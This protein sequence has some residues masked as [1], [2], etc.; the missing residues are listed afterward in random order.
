MTQPLLASSSTLLGSVQNNTSLHNNPPP[1]TV[2]EPENSDQQLLEAFQA[3]VAHAASAMTP[4]AAV[5]ITYSPDS[6]QVDNPATTIIPSIPGVLPSI[7]SAAIHDPTPTTP[8]IP[9]P[10]GPSTLP[11]LSP[12]SPTPITNPPSS[13]TYHYSSLKLPRVRNNK[14]PAG[15]KG[16]HQNLTAKEMLDFAPISTS[17]LT[18][19]SFW[20]SHSASAPSSRSPRPALPSGTNGVVGLA[21]AFQSSS[22]LTNG[23]AGIDLSQFVNV[24]CA[25]TATTMPPSVEHPRSI[26]P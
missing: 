24:S 23:F 14:H 10:T 21:P 3:V 1:T 12:Q 19:D 20:S 9:A 8:T 6:M 5:N 13:S 18:Y 16:A 7:P 22:L 2:T 15:P 17:P 11:L 4:D 26:A 25:P